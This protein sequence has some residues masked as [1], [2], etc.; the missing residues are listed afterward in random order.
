MLYEMIILKLKA[1]V[2]WFVQLELLPHSH[3]CTAP[4][5]RFSYNKTKREL[6]PHKF[7]YYDCKGVFCGNIEEKDCEACERF[8]KENKERFTEKAG[9]KAH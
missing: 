4:Y 3:V 9:S 6:C 2:Q 7:E 1:L 8:V 5:T